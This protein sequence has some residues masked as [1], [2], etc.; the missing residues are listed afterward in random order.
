MFISNKSDMSNFH[1]REVVGRDGE[2]QLQVGENLNLKYIWVGKGLILKKRHQS[3]RNG[4]VINYFPVTVNKSTVK[5][6]RNNNI[7]CYVRP[8]YSVLWRHS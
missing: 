8:H 3:M 4:N 1:P 6:L 5:L 7:A 2:T